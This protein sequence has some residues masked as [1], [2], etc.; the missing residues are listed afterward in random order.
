MLFMVMRMIKVKMF[1]CCH[2]LDLEE[3]MNEFLETIRDEDLLSV[4]YQTTFLAGDE[5]ED[6]IYSYSAML[7]YKCLNN[8]D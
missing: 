8:E 2:E 3:E 7:I 1:D 6:T 4:E 5:D